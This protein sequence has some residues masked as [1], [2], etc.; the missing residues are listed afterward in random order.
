MQ[1]FTNNSVNFDADGDKNHEGA[2]SG[3]NLRRHESC[4]MYQSP[5]LNEPGTNITLKQQ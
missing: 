5:L 4:S 3:N 2:A 1:I